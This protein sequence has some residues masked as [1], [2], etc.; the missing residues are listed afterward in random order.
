ELFAISV[1]LKWPGLR[2]V[3]NGWDIS[4]WHAR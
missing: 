1:V 2:Y 3:G 4:S